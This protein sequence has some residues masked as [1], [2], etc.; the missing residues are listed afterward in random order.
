MRGALQFLPG[1]GRGT[2]AEGGGGGAPPRLDRV[3]LDPS[4]EPLCAPV[5]LPVNGE[6]F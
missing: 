1:T 5:P 6:E 3:G 4:T 2:A